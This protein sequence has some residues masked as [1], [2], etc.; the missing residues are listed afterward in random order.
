LKVVI[1]GIF[2]GGVSS[3]DD[4]ISSIIIMTYIKNLGKMSSI[5]TDWRIVLERG[6]DRHVFPLTY[7]SNLYLGTDEL[8]GRTIRLSE[9]DAIYNRASS[10]IPPGGMAQGFACATVPLDM[11]GE[12]A[13]G[14]RVLL[15]CEDINGNVCTGERALQ[16]GGEL[17]YFPG[18]HFEPTE[19]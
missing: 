10:P 5:A 1:N 2:W 4:N 16:L 15:E 13:A 3:R 14:S 11:L 7:A 19:G 6:N 18:M 8:S 9:E 12:D 17:R